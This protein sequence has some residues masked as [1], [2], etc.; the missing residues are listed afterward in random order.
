MAA[1]RHRGARRPGLERR[2]QVLLRLAHRSGKERR[3]RA[4]GFRLL[5]RAVVAL[6]FRQ[7]G[8]GVRAGQSTAAAD[9]PE[10]RRHFGYGSALQ[11]RRRNLRRKLGLAAQLSGSRGVRTEGQRLYEAKRGRTS[12]RQ[13]SQTTRP[14][15]TALRALQ[16]DCLHGKRAQK[17]ETDR[18]S[19]GARYQRGRERNYRSGEDVGEERPGRDRKSTRLN[20]SHVEIS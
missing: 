6:V 11:E 20:S 18:R 17:Q 10:S 3:G 19:G 13:G 12:Q 14:R 16:P 2:R 5:Q 15:A 7:A 9:V 1:A 4:Y 8:D